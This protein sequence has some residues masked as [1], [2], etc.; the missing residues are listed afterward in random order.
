MKKIIPL[1]LSLSILLST[2]FIVQVNAEEYNGYKVKTYKDFKY[3][4]KENDQVTITKYTGNAAS[5]KI[6]S[7]IKGK[8]VR[9]I[10]SEAFADIYFHENK[11]LKR[12]T[13]PDSI[14]KIKSFAFYNCVNLNKVTIGKNVKK[15][16]RSAF[17]YCA[18]LND[19]KILNKNADIRRCA[20]ENCG[21]KSVEVTHKIDEGFRSCKKLEK[22]TINPDVEVIG[23]KQFYSCPKLKIVT[24]P[25]TVKSIEKKAFGFVYKKEKIKTV[26][27]KGFTIKGKAD[28][29]AHRYA[30][31]HG[32]K[33]IEI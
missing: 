27:I 21:F 1:V 11:T 29:A 23:W 19:V 17:A 4:V 14:R 20:F 16:E 26:K 2:C 24:I 28:S 12:I 33:F 32:F 15:I 31:E 8:T 5:V 18:K 30:Q 3:I 10:G 22:I 13:I 25:S 7:K 9:I 6:P